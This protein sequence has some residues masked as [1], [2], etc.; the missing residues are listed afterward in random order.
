MSVVHVISWWVK[1]SCTNLQILVRVST[2]LQTGEFY[3]YTWWAQPAP[4]EKI[5]GGVF[6]IYRYMVHF[7][8]CTAFCP[9]CFLMA[10]GR[11]GGEEASGRGGEPNFDSRFGG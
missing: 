3:P 7:D 1:V 2:V 10:A 4:S 6:F 9:K 8:I 5:G 11:S